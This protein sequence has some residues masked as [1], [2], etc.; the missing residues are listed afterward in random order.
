ML[1]VIYLSLFL[2]SAFHQHQLRRYG[3]KIFHVFKHFAEIANIDWGQQADW[4]IGQED[5]PQQD[6]GSDCGVFVCQF[7]E[8]ESRNAPFYF[9]AADMPQLRKVMKYEIITQDLLPRGLAIAT[10]TVMPLK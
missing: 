2:D 5:V 10:T 1:V 8:C 3:E 7:F 4:E 9:T 6:N